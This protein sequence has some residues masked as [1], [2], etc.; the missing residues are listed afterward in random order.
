MARAVFT[1]YVCVHVAVCLPSTERGAVGDNMDPQ[2]AP[3]TWKLHKPRQGAAN[4]T[5]IKTV[6]AAHENTPGS[7]SKSTQ[8][9]I[10]MS[11]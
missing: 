7:S 3:V 10:Q 5:G 8:I 9:G 6:T 2:G 1:Q 4:K 11:L